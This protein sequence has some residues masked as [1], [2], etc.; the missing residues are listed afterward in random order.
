LEGLLDL[1]FLKEGGDGVVDGEGA[2]GAACD[3]ERLA[4]GVEIERLSGGLG[5]GRIGWQWLL[6]EGDELCFGPS[7]ERVDGVGLGGFF[8]LG[9]VGD[10]GDGVEVDEDAV[11]VFFA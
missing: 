10:A 7:F 6:G 2:L 1:F 3:E 9:L 5:G 11:V 8:V 4:V